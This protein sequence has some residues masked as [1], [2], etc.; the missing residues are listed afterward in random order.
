MASSEKSWENLFFRAW[1][2]LSELQLVGFWAWAVKTA[3]AG[4]FGRAF[5]RVVRELY[6]CS[7]VCRRLCAFGEKKSGHVG[8]CR[9]K[10]GEIGCFKFCSAR[11]NGAIL[12]RFDRFRGRFPV[13]AASLGPSQTQKH[14]DFPAFGVS[15]V[16]NM[17]VWSIHVGSR[18][19]KSG[20]GGKCRVHVGLSQMVSVFRL[21]LRSA[22]CVCR[23]SSGENSGLGSR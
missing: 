10:S 6:G 9:H 1:G 23:P 22:F 14:V 16:V 12:H 20:H 13:Q 18:L 4:I 3:L 8:S 21:L 19:P 5:A 2:G 15:F 7:Q 11:F 17:V